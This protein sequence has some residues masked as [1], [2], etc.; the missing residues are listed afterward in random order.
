MP[1][2]V[3]RSD[4]TGSPQ[5]KS[6]KS[7]KQLSTTRNDVLTTFLSRADDQ[8]IRLGQLLQPLHQLRQI[9]SVLGP[10][11]NL[12][13]GRHAVLHV[14][15]VVSIFDCHQSARL[16]KELV[17]TN[18]GDSISTRNVGDL[19]SSTPHVQHCSLNALGIEVFL[20]SWP[21]VRALDRHLLSCG[22]TATEHTTESD[23]YIIRGPARQ[24]A[25]IAFAAVSSVGPSYKFSPRYF[26]AVLGEGKRMTIIANSVSAVMVKGSTVPRFT[27]CCSLKGDKLPL[28]MNQ[29]PSREP[30]FDH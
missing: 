19:L 3:S 15:N 14:S 6:R 25:R 1:A 20:A 13:N 17:H 26:F 12:H 11:C 7:L 22:D 21:V 9:L 30:V 18:E 28:V 16:Q 24:K 8:W 4:T 5:V 10:H 29:A 23:T 27:S 2:T